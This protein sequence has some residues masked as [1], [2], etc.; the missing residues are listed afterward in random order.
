M[1]CVHRCPLAQHRLRAGATALTLTPHQAKY[2]AHDPTRRAT[3]MDRLSM[4][5]FD[6][7]VDLNPQQ[8]EASLFALRSPL[9][10]GVA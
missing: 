2:F 5:L 6:A 8:I 9:S 7:A 3:G 1:S 4:G 10:K